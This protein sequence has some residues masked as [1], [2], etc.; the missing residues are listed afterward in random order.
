MRVGGLA[1]LG[2]IGGI[3]L[4]LRIVIVKDALLISSRTF[5]WVNWVIVVVLIVAGGAGVMVRQ[6][7]G[8][9]SLCVTYTVRDGRYNTDLLRILLFYG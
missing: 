8:I 1:L 2:I 9:V 6:R 4:G 5:Y 3:A 7:I